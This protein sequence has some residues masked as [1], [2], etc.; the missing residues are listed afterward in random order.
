MRHCSI[1]TGTNKGLGNAL[2]Q[3][4][5]SN[6]EFIISI[7]RNFQ[8]Y[9]HE[10]QDDR[11]AVLIEKDLSTLRS[12]DIELDLKDILRKFEIDK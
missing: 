1:I 12:P 7:S 2:F 9:Q 11:K 3:V 10:Y 5:K 6:G 4:L 8:K